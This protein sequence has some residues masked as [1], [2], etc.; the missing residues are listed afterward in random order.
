MAGEKDQVGVTQAQLNA[1][2]DKFNQLAAEKDD[3]AAQ[4]GA[5]KDEASRLRDRLKVVESRGS[6]KEL[7]VSE[8]VLGQ[9]DIEKY[10]NEPEPDSAVYFIRYTDKDTES[11]DREVQIPLLADREEPVT[12]HHSVHVSAPTMKF[13]KP[14]HF[15]LRESNYTVLRACLTEIDELRITSDDIAR[16]ELAWAGQDKD[17]PRLPKGIQVKNGVY[18]VLELY[19]H[20][21]LRLNAP[22]I[23]GK[24]TKFVVNPWDPT[25]NQFID[26]FQTG[27]QFQGLAKIYYGERLR[28]NN[29]PLE[30][31]MSIRNI[32][33]P[34]KVEITADQRRD[35]ARRN[36]P[37]PAGR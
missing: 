37:E 11:S 27:E 23:K 4:V 15:I 28:R 16:S 30:T 19:E 35:L 24:K 18:G 33:A 32:A 20:M 25:S 21:K 1:L 10:L 12:Q 31:Q 34:N 6:E 5:S 7:S 17:F 36:A 29:V 3:L 9:K 14:G 2:E 22:D 26:C 13:G 8:V